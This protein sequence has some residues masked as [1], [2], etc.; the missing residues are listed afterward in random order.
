MQYLEDVAV[1]T[2]KQLSSGQL[3]INRSPKSLTDKIFAFAIKYNWVRDQIFGRAEKQVLKLT[4]G[5]YP[6]PLKVF[7]LFTDSG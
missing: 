6:A 5:L 1:A 3:K 7:Y 4:G 2:A